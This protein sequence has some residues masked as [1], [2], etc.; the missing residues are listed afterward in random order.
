MLIK[1]K[2]FSKKG[3]FSHTKD[4]S[5]KL[6]LRDHLFLRKI[7]LV[8][9]A[10]IVL[11]DSW[12]LLLSTT[13][14]SMNQRKNWNKKNYHVVEI[15]SQWHFFFFFLRGRRVWVYSEI[16]IGDFFESSLPTSFLYC[17][18]RPN[19]VVLGWFFSVLDIFSKLT[20]KHVLLCIILFLN[21]Y[22]SR[23]RR[24]CSPFMQYA[25]IFFQFFSHISDVLDTLSLCKFMCEAIIKIVLCNKSLVNLAMSIFKQ[26]H[27]C[28]Y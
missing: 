23:K 7:Y 8:V 25:H 16:Q 18:C 26:N 19:K 4:H 20:K 11:K 28:Q 13:S 17:C 6:L 21:R 12:K 22:K 2:R 24:K 9:R 1:I 14:S 27:F 3:I 10:I 15:H 5:E